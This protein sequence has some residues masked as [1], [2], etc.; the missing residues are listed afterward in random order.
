MLKEIAKNHPEILA[1]A[2]NEA[3][4]KVAS[5]IREKEGGGTTAKA[6]A[7]MECNRKN[8]RNRVEQ[9]TEAA[10]LGCLMAAA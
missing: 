10:L 3:R 1:F 4:E 6:V 9:Y 7:L 5:E 8:I 2:E